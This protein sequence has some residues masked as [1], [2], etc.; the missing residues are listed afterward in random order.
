[1]VWG[2]RVC[3]LGVFLDHI[4]PKQYTSNTC[5]TK[6]HKL[7]SID[8]TPKDTQSTSAV[9]PKAAYETCRHCNLDPMNP[10]PML[11]HGLT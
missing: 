2:F 4:D 1:M 7:H 5:H 9:K 3:G 10:I 8:L 11:S 6:P